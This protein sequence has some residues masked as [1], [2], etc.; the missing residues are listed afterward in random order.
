MT[1]EP[2]NLSRSVVWATLLAVAMLY[3]YPQN[4]AAEEPPAAEAPPAAIDEALAKAQGEGEPK[5]A[6]LLTAPGGVPAE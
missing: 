4:A 6:D 3:A 1:R 5:V 2:G